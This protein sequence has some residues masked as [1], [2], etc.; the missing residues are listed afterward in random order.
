MFIGIDDFQELLN[1]GN[2]SNRIVPM[3]LEIRPARYRLDESF[4]TFSN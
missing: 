2:L 1:A 4:T 3:P